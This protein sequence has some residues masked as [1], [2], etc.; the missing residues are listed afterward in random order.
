MSGIKLPRQPV[1]GFS[2][3]DI[4]SLGF[5]HRCKQAV[6]CLFFF[7]SGKRKMVNPC[8]IIVVL[9][10]LGL[11]LSLVMY[12]VQ[13]G[14]ETSCLVFT[15]QKCFIIALYFRLGI[16]YLPHLQGH[17]SKRSIMMCFNVDSF[18]F[19]GLSVFYFDQG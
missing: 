17:L 16:Q 1:L 14:T 12:I 3:A 7:P 9:C 11:G 8:S 5:F 4:S 13:R 6:L 18:Y 10:A 2:T 19:T 15:H